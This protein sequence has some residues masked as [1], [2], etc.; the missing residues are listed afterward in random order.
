M[1]VHVSGPNLSIFIFQAQRAIRTL[2]ADLH[3]TVEIEIS[4]NKEI[5]F[6]FR[7]ESRL[8][9]QLFCYYE[10]THFM[11]ILLGSGVF[12]LSV[13]TILCCPPS[14]TL[15]SEESLKMSPFCWLG[16]TCR[17]T[18]GG[19]TCPCCPTWWSRLSPPCPA[20]RPAGSGKKSVYH[21]SQSQNCLEMERG[22]Q[23]VLCHPP[24][25]KL[26]ILSH[27]K[28]YICLWYLF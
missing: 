6:V 22:N 18:C 19:M 25:I 11:I 17:D 7:C 28:F 21:W 13:I 5:N 16:L 9:W 24:S 10:M 20:T 26:T 27:H 4:S 8:S 12:F 14:A 1:S 2:R 15:I 3:R 23:N